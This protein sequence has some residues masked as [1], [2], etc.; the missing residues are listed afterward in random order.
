MAITRNQHKQAITQRAIATFS[1][2]NDP[3]M[4]LSGFFPSFTTSDKLV[5]IEVERNRQLLAVDIQRGTQGNMNT[6]S[7]YTE[8]LFQPPMF[9][10]KFNFTELERYDVTFGRNNNPSVSDSF[11]MIREASQRLRT[12]RAKIERAITKQQAEALQTGIVTLKNGDNID[13]KRKA[14]SMPVLT[15]TDVW[16]NSA[17][18]PFADLE[19]GCKFLRQEGLSAGSTVNALFGREAFSAFMSNEKV[20]AEGDIRRIER[21]TLGFPQLNSI[22]GLAFH[23]QISCFDFIV[24]IWTYNE[25][26]ELDNGTKVNYLDNKNVVMIAEDF[27]ARTS[28]AGVP[29]IM[30]DR[31]NAEY[32]EFISQVEAEFYVNN[33]IDPTKKAHFFDLCSAPLAIPV[34]IDRVYTVK[35][36]A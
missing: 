20:K 23:G 11:S 12:L 10:E 17:S 1:D 28:Y 33:Y 14:A 16:T 31:N 21:V 26:Y 2:M 29:A 27:E 36:L 19:N 32:P 3:K 9:E 22:T 34:S 30:R 13:F 5:S 4:G 15:G 35:V 6:F 18:N 7:N 8:K 24:N 25:F